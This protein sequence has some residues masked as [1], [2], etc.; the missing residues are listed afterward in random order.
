MTLELYGILSCK[1]LLYTF[2]SCHIQHTGK[3]SE[4]GF[5]PG[6]NFE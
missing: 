1:G 2:Q 5:G 3:L 6:A 4:L